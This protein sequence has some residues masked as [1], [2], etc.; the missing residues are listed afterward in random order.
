MKCGIIGTIKRERNL[1]NVKLKKEIIMKEMLENLSRAAQSVE[2]GKRDLDNI[3][4]FYSHLNKMTEQAMNGK[5]RYT[6]V[7][8]HRVSDTVLEK[9]KEIT[10]CT[11]DHNNYY[12]N[13][14]TV[15]WEVK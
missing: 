8:P 12:P 10:G 5:D 14:V 9:V 11:I 1:S 4:H 2:Q 13:D 6:F 7:F 15:I 3:A